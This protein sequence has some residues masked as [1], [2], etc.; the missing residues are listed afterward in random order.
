VTRIAFALAA[1]LVAGCHVPIGHFTVLGDPAT[2]VSG[3]RPST[4][5]TTGSSCRWWVL[6]ITLGVPSMQEAI[7]D[8]LANAG[9]SGVLADVDL[10][11]DHP[12]YG[13]AGEHCYV[14]SGVPWAPPPVHTTP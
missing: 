3:A 1:I 9:A 5:R 7:D 4:T 6:G 12:I 13:L 14:V 11:S 8:A 2:I 10:V